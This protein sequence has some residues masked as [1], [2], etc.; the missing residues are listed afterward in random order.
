M[1]SKFLVVD[2][3]SLMHHIENHIPRE[4]DSNQRFY[5][6][7]YMIQNLIQDRKYEYVCCVCTDREYQFSAFFQPNQINKVEKKVNDFETL[8]RKAGVYVWRNDSF[9]SYFIIKKLI[10][11]FQSDVEIE[12][13]SDDYKM[14]TLV[15]ENSSFYPLYYDTT[16]SVEVIRNDNFLDCMGF[17]K[18]QMQDYLYFM[19][20]YKYVATCKKVGKQL[21][22]NFLQSHVSIKNAQEN[23]VS[24][25]SPMVKHMIKEYD[26]QVWK[27][28]YESYMNR[29]CADIEVP[30]SLTTFAVDICDHEWEM[31]ATSVFDDASYNL[32]NNTNDTNKHTADINT[33]STNKN[34]AGLVSALQNMV[35]LHTKQE[36]NDLCDKITALDYNTDIGIYIWADSDLSTSIFMKKSDTSEGNALG[37]LSLFSNETKMENIIYAVAICV[38]EKIYVMNLQEID[39]QEVV[40]AEQIFKWLQL[41]LVFMDCR[42]ILYIL[43]ALACRYH[44]SESVLQYQEMEKCFDI[45]LARYLLDPIADGY[46]YETMAK[47]LFSYD[48]DDEKTLLQ[49]RNRKQALEED[50]T[51]ILH[52]CALQAYMASHGKRLLMED[53]QAKGMLDLYQSVELPLLYLLFQL[54]KRGVSMEVETLV[55]YGKK[56]EEQIHSLEQQ[57]YAEVGEEFNINSPKQLGQILFDKLKMPYGKKTKTGYSTSADVLEKLKKEYPVVANVLAYRQLSKLKSTYADGLVAYVSEVD[58]RIHS[59]LHQTITATGRLSST[60]PNLQNIPIR[61][62]IGREIRKVF[63]P[64]ENY[65]FLDADY[66]QIELR[67]LA[68]M[69]ADANLIAAYNQGKDIHRTTA[70]EV[71]HVPFE[72]VTDLQRRSAKAV[73]F[74]IVYGISA[75]GLAEDL[76][77]SR[78]EAEG[79]IEEY[80]ASYPG[81][82]KYLK[83]TVACAKKEGYAISLL[84]RRRPIPEL[85]ATNHMKKAFGE[86]IAMNSPIQATAADVIKIAMLRVENRMRKEQLQ[87]QLLL[88]IH[89]ELLVETHPDEIEQVKCILQ[90]EMENVLRLSVPLKVEVEQGKNWNEAH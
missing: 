74:G 54:E 29:D 88:Q 30:A 26:A 68:H 43:Q 65:V 36:W 18:E 85:Q 70:A 19:E 59:K 76:G 47:D 31:D 55:T 62:E 66:S 33:R 40:V 8:M 17:E 20:Y 84:G 86:R 82:Q 7:N 1:K 64:K 52:I 61:M 89:D 35:I 69:S 46:T 15:G 83:K 42:Q 77:I 2:G 78:K 23:V 16:N 63:V 39:L 45:T 38:E 53:L 4:V 25:T 12:V 71:F 9:D 5:A 41:S 10:D 44:L 60:E 58:G 87:S 13:L 24:I 50:E 80:F 34:T 75:F 73:N 79:Y 51:K 48:V 27:S 6:C 57:I 67:L 14:L 81:I 56:L 90:E 22:T 37:Q 49:K 11:S 3:N 28:T 21:I 72:E 32:G